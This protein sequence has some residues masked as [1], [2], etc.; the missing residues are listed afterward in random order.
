M[1]ERSALRALA[2]R[3]GILPSYI[4][5]EGVTRWTS[6]ES[7][8][9]ILSAMGIDA[10]SE[11]AA[12]GELEAAEARSARRSLDSVIVQSAHGARPPRIT[13]RPPGSL[14]GTNF[15]YRME[16]EVESGAVH[17]SEGQARLP[18]DQTQ[19]AVRLP[20]NPGPG[21][22]TLRLELG[23]GSA[24]AADQCSLILCP[25]SCLTAREMLKGQRR[26]GFWTH[27][28]SA[29][30]DHDW[31]VGDIGVLRTVVDWA[32]RS[33]AAFVGLNP[34]HALNNRGADISPYSPVSRL[35]RN[36]LYIDVDQIPEL[37]DCPEAR[38]LI[39]SP[40]F[41]Q[42]LGALRARRHIDYEGVMA[43]KASVFGPLYRTFVTRHRDR[44]TERG[45]AYTRF[46]ERRGDSLTDFATF[47]ALTDHL[48]SAHGPDWRLWP[49]SYRSPRTPEVEAFRRDHA[50]Q[51]DRQRYLQFELDR[52]IESVAAAGSLPVGLYGDLAIGTAPNGS[53]PWMFP[54][55]FIDGATVGA[56][57]DDYSRDGQNW[58][59]PPVDPVKL[60]ADA[61]RYWII[62]LR[63]ALEHMGALRIDHV[64]GLFRQFW[65]PEGRPATEGAYV[66]FPAD[67]LLGILALESRRHGSLI[68]GEDLG[69][70]PRGLPAV[71]DRWG[72]LSSRVLYFEKD[73]RGNYHPARRYSPRALVT[74]NT[75]DHPPLVGFWRG[76]DLELRDQVGN[77]GQG[78]RLADA[79]EERERERRALVM[80]LRRERCLSEP[81]TAAP[82]PQLCKSVYAMLA[83]TPAPLLG[84][85]LDDL[86]GEDDPVNLPGIGLDRYP[87]WSRRLTRSIEGLRQDASVEEALSGLAKRT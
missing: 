70:V 68:I 59:L 51:V 21:Y 52:Q 28:Y 14:T 55:L 75:H 54:D 33:H 44:N 35:Y 50:D 48:N 19:V 41:Q 3:Q 17:V 11:A 10:S 16:L 37:A 13:F 86:A 45:R 47:V 2:E 56:P 62:L 57:P 81:I 15:D 6:D 83:R 42:N 7:R 67:D 46:L 30:G 36:T 20:V 8:V 77:L 71:L 40:E 25:S 82:Y 26:F 29:R 22:H 4:D 24:A 74:A 78:R 12:G 27:L 18:Q 49:T 23:S 60:K 34:L 80:R 69:T 84:V 66:R 43:L 63:N 9:A 53:D 79:M 73:D 31:G 39:A 87:G 72:I 1:K 65:I 38:S 85:W 61:Y 76:R 64:M 58:A 32:A 5:N